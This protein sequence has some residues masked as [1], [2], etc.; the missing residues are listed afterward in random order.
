MILEV[1]ARKSNYQKN[2][3]AGDKFDIIK[4][5]NDKGKGKNSFVCKTYDG[6]KVTISDDRFDI[7]A[8]NGSLEDLRKIEILDKMRNRIKYAKESE[9]KKKTDEI[10]Y[11][12]KTDPELKELDLKIRL[13]EVMVVSKTEDLC[14]KMAALRASEWKK[15]TRALREDCKDMRK[16]WRMCK[17][18]DGSYK[19]FE[20]ACENFE[21][22]MSANLTKIWFS[23][24]S[25]VKNINYLHNEIR[26]DA[27]IISMIYTES[28]GLY[29][30]FCNKIGVNPTEPTY[31]FH[32]IFTIM[33]D[34]AGCCLKEYKDI[35]VFLSCLHNEFA[36][37]RFMYEDE[38]NK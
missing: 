17:F 34:I 4:K 11:R 2:I 23:I 1:I 8:I 22:M 31:S 6:K 35:H 16:R 32:D 33:N 3:K 30:D 12:V 20:E 19:T 24:N 14:N 9:C 21:N 36:K 27:L 28:R 10:I 18:D 37:T 13:T 38:I 29:F 26:T 5:V 7:I 25:W 15:Q